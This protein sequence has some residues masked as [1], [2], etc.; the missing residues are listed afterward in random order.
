MCLRVGVF[1]VRPTTII[2]INTIT[3]SIV[4]VLN[5]TRVNKAWRSLVD[6]ITLCIDTV[7]DAIII[8]GTQDI[9]HVTDI[10][11]NVTPICYGHLTHL[12]H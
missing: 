5:G 10:S 9:S 6:I 1:K 3:I 8:C 2:V 7:L 4:R 12:G 11:T